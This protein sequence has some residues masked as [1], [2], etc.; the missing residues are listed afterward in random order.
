MIPS[1]AMLAHISED[2][3]EQTILAHLQGTAKLA[4]E[5]A[6]P[7]GGEDQA[8]LAGMAHDIGKYSSAFQKR[9][10]GDPHMV[11]HTTAGAYECGRQGQIFAAFAVMGHHSG[12]PDGG[13]QAD[14]PV[15]TTF[16]GRM[17]RRERGSLAPYSAWKEEVRLPMAAAP[18]YAQAGL[19]QGMFFTRMLCSCLVD[20]DYLDTEAFM[21]GQARPSS[22][23][24][25]EQLWSNLRQYISGWFPPHGALN[26]QRCAILERCIQNGESC[27]PGLFSLTVPTG[28]GKTVASLAFA[29]AHAR[30]YGLRRVI[31]VIPYTSIIEQTA[32]VFRKILGEDAVLEHHSNVLYDI[33]VGEEANAQ[34]IRMVKAT[35]NWDMPVIVTTAVQFFESLYASRPSKCRKLHNI[36]GSVVIFDEAQ[37]MPIPYLRPCVYSISQLVKNYG[38]SAVLCTA[39]QPALGPIFHEFLPQ[40]TIIELCPP[41]TYRWKV[42]RRVT[43]QKRGSL[44]W[45]ELAAQLNDSR[46]VLCIVNTRKAAQVIYERLKGDGRFHLSTL[47]YPNHRKRQLDEIRRRLGEGLPCRVVSTSLI[48]AGVD[49]DFPAVWREE[50]GLDSILQAAG[51]CNRE[52]KR[53]PAESVVSIFRG[54]SRIPELFSMPIGAG[55]NIMMHHQDIASPEAIHDYFQQLLILKGKQAQD[56]QNILQ[57]QEDGTLPFRTVAEQFR[58]I[59]VPTRTVY[60]PMEDGEM[61]VEQLRQGER[62]RSLFRQLGQYGVSIYE[63]HYRALEQ[64]GDLEVLEDGSAVLWN[65][66]LYSEQ[67]GLSLTADDGKFLN[68]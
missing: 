27:R 46:Q 48:E 2:N 16:W 15:D 6:R 50:A 51:R 20:A 13:T 37:M 62:S 43:F 49:V 23:V 54:E 63:Q 32:E 59:D 65:I 42:F 11:D 12:L 26:E 56:K 22:L 36:A 10:R 5:F 30:A 35:E 1:D 67:T 3:R 21:T 25:M 57:L 8:Q 66:G 34:T 53:S 45:D 41:N 60:I 29:L 64:A 33:G 24:S 55:R 68:I 17:K 40:Q 9:L 28:G 7:F 14:S 52:G 4:K 47:M 38:V 18:A 31:Y 19:A 39:T 61:L 58:L 44:T